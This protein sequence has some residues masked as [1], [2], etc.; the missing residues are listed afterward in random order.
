MQ[1]YGDFNVLKE[2]PVQSS[3]HGP[4]FAVC[5]RAK[6]RRWDRPL[7]T[8]IHVDAMT[9][10]SGASRPSSEESCAIIASSP[11]KCSSSAI[12]MTLR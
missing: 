4:V 6:S 10:G 9:I 3:R 12:I 1:G 7:F 2:L 5:K 8:R 11:S